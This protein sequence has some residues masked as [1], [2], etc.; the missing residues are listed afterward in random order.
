MELI[1]E[2]VG[3]KLYRDGDRLIKS[4]DESYSKAGILNEALNQARVEETGLNIP[5]VL[6]VTVV[7]GR[8]SLIWEYIEGETLES[9]MQ[10]HPE[11][12]DE[13]LDF[14]VDL[15]QLFCGVTRRA[16]HQR[17]AALFCKGKQIVQVGRAGKID[18]GINFLR[19]FVKAVVHGYAAE[20]ALF[21]VDARGAANV[22]VRLCQF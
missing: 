5:K 13:Y 3:K 9:L 16:E 22:C 11:K 1:H 10:K 21:Q 20:F 15:F 7:D 12:E 19:H 18:H 4:F 14:F 2:S 6:G 8:W 17:A